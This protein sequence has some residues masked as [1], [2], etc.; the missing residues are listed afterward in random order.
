MPTWILTPSTWRLK[1]DRTDSKY[2]SEPTGL[3]NPKAERILRFYLLNGS[4]KEGSGNTYRNIAKEVGVSL[5][6]VS[7]VNKEVG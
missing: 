2:P 1:G 6:Q 4:E 5:G 3:F 7:K